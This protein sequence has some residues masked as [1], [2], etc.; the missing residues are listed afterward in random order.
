M[1]SVTSAFC[2]TESLLNDYTPEAAVDISGFQLYWADGVQEMYAFTSNNFGAMMS[3]YWRN[4]DP[5]TW[6]V[7]SSPA[8]CFIHHVP[9]ALVL[10]FRDPLQIIFV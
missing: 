2:F 8:I 6:N 3:L 7:F 10:G 5:L 1:I 4:L 9:H